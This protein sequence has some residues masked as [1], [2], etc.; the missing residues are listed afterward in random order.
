[1]LNIKFTFHIEY[2]HIQLLDNFFRFFTFQFNTSLKFNRFIPIMFLANKIK[3]SYG[4][5]LIKWKILK[6]IIRTLI[7]IYID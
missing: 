6:I 5:R 4:I 2:I 3:I 7:F 1:M